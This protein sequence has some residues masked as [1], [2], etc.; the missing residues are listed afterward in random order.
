MTHDYYGTQMMADYTMMACPSGYDNLMSTGY[1]TAGHYMNERLVKTIQDC[2]ATCEHMTNYLKKMPDFQMRVNQAVLLR[3]CADIC[4]L[5]AKFV[6]RG[7]VFARQTTALC[8]CIC[9]ACGTE[10]ARFPDQMSQN[11]ARVCMHCAREC[12]AFAGM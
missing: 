12:R 1:P 2:E 8:A 3:D 11:C 6:A 7:A 5:T 10:C 9:E 4:G